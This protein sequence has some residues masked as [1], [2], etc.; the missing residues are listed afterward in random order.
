MLRR[1][2]LGL[3]KGSLVGGLLAYALVAG[4]SVQ[5]LSGGFAYA[6]VVLVG[7]LSALVAGRPIWAAG[8]RI[9]VLLKSIAAALLG[10]GLL[11][12]LNRYLSVQVDWGALGSGA[13]AQLPYVLLPTVGVLLSLFFEVDNDASQEEEPGSREGA[14]ARRFRVDDEGTDESLLE[15]SAAESMR[16]AKRR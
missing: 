13:L 5:V 7:V 11:F 4:L 10:S 14:D 9:E 8:A 2:L 1:L 12:L 6:A 15:E 16:Q 3:I